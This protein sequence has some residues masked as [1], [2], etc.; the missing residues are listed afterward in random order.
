MTR[1]PFARMPD[2]RPRE[3]S[4]AVEFAMVAFPFFF[5]MFAIIEIGMIFVTD[6]MLEN[7][8]IESGRLVRT[9][10]AA[11]T[12]VTADAFKAQV[13]SRMSI[14]SSQCSS[15]ATVDVREISQFRNQTPPDPM[16]NGTTF[17]PSQLTYQ[18]GQPGSL[19]L[20]R[21][22]YRQP[23]FTPFLAQALSR[24]NDGAN[25]MT[26]TTTFRNEPYDQ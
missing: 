12:I 13:C 6:S 15:R 18:P 21:V 7:A 20:V 25:I 14:F 16:A 2:R 17:D 5:M 19:M 9:G 4:S 26:A 24:L 8:A 11:G 3:G 1:R 23:L 22:W 10:Q